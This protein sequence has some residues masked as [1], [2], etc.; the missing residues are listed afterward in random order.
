MVAMSVLLKGRGP[1]P[2]APKEGAG[3]RR[4]RSA[5][6]GRTPYGVDGIRR[7]ETRSRATKRGGF[8]VREMTA[9]ATSAIQAQAYPS[10]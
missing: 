4:H 5:S 9:F 10:Q 1:S 6:G 8:R 3:S 7:S 2:M